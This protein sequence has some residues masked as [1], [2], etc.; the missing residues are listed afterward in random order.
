MFYKLIGRLLGKK[1][2]GLKTNS[3]NSQDNI[4]TSAWKDPD[5]SNQIS[6]EYMS[7]KDLWA[8]QHL[9]MS[10]N[11]FWAKSFTII[12]LLGSWRVIASFLNA[13]RCYRKWVCR[14]METFREGGRK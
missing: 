5:N 4:S 12:A 3:Q 1:L 13:L 14:E 9:E 6:N 10:S 7:A 2:S 8:F 11:S